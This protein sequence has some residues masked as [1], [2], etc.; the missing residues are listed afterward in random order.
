MCV[1]YCSHC[2]VS[3]HRTRRNVESTT[4]NASGS[5]TLRL[6]SAASSTSE[7]PTRTADC[8]LIPC[9]YMGF[10]IW[11]YCHNERYRGKLL[12]LS[13]AAPLM[14]QLKLQQQWQVFISGRRL[15]LNAWLHL[16]QIITKVRTSICWAPF[17]KHTIIFHRAHCRSIRLSKRSQLNN[18]LSYFRGA[19]NYVGVFVLLK[20]I[21]C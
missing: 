17:N 1:R 9:F 16:Y 18:R 12:W 10:L 19:I 7:Q 11:I 20:M 3:T 14:A 6:P 21:R 13:V 5:A 2:I 15:C 4:Q 8:A